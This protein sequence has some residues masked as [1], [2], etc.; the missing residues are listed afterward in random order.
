M[1]PLQVLRSRYIDRKKL[2][3]LLNTLYPD[4]FIIEVRGLNSKINKLTPG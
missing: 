2:A 3:A 1:M 4:N